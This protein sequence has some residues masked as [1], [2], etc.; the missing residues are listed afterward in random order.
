MLLQVHD[1]IIFEVPEDM[2]ADVVPVLKQE[3]TCEDYDIPLSVTIKVGQN[4]KDLHEY[5]RESTTA[6]GATR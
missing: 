1:E 4:W 6:S 2:V 5:Q 3:L